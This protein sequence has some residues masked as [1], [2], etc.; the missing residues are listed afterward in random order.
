MTLE[1]IVAALRRAAARSRAGRYG[2]HGLALAVGW[3]AAIL[4]VAR[5][6]PIERKAELAV[7]GLP[8][9][10][11]LATIAWFVRRP[12]SAFLMTIADLRLGLKE[13]LSTAWERRNERGALDA[14]LRADALTRASR[15]RLAAA[16]PLR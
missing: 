10:L 4:L 12:S 8:I 7:I 9:A 6:T 5:V 11:L 3:L 2:L 13:R 16:F 14:A 1:T 15:A